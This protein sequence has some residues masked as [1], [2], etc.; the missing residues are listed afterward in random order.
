MGVTIISKEQFAVAAQNL[1]NK[2]GDNNPFNIARDIGIQVIFCDHFSALKGMY[3]VV[4]RNRFI[5]INSNLSEKMQRIV[6]AHELGHDQLHRHLAKNVA[7]QE[8]MLYE[9]ASTPE[10]EANIFAA[11]LLIDTKEILEYIYDYEYSADQLASI[12]KT[13]VNLIALKLGYLRELGYDLR[14]LEHRSDFL[15]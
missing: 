2:V 5:F 11:E 14:T 6:C 12:F 1:I 7:L 4:K 15:K 10:Y 3:T 9:M 8:F 13:D